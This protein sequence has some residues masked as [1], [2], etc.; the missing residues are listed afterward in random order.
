MEAPPLRAYLV[1]DEP[2]ALE[3]L[4]RLLGSF[5]AIEIAGSATDPA[6]AAIPLPVGGAKG[7]GLS[8][9]VECLT[10][11]L[12]AAPILVGHSVLIMVL[13][14]LLLEI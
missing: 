7:S 5:E 3:R 9:M 13:L 14:Q 11:L 4:K 6:R 1:D 12:G 2:L 10:S 8:L